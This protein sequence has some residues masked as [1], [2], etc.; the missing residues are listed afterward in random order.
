MSS[1]VINILAG[2]TINAGRFVA[3][4]GGLAIQATSASATIIGIAQRSAASGEMASVVIDGF[5]NLDMAGVVAAGGYIKADSDGKGVA[6]TVGT[7][8]NA[9]LIDYTSSGDTTIPSTASGDNR[10]VLLVPQFVYSAA[11]PLFATATLDFGPIGAGATA[12]LTTTVTGAATGD[13]VTVNAASLEADLVIGDAW[14]SAADTVTIRVGNI[15]AGSIDPASQNF[16]IKVEP[17]T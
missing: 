17:A 13:F 14:V 15:S 5:A 10:R 9:R 16:L 7:R 4:S 8:T 6:A 11:L 12:E 2:G 3:L 1:T